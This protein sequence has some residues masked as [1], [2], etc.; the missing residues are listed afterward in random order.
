[1]PGVVIIANS[2]AVVFIQIEC[3]NILSFVNLQTN[4]EGNH[5]ITGF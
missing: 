4:H 3:Q 2:Y 1:M 5:I